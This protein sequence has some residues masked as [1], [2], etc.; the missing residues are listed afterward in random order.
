MKFKE[1]LIKESSCPL[2]TDRYGGIGT[3]GGFGSNTE[4]EIGAQIIAE[5]THCILGSLGK[6]IQKDNTITD[7]KNSI[8][9]G[10][11]KEELKIIQESVQEYSKDVYSGRTFD[12]SKYKDMSIKSIKKA[13]TNLVSLAK[14]KRKQVDTSTS[15]NLYKTAMDSYDVLIA[16]GNAMNDSVKKDPITNGFKNSKLNNAIKTLSRGI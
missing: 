16:L 3:G 7:I 9:E 13:A 11:I 12:E 1:Y 8:E 14:K 10:H 5:A 2:A 6:L 15:K 4:Y